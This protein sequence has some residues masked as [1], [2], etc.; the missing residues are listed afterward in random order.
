MCGRY[1]F[2]AE[3]CEEIR[4]IAQAIQKKYGKGAWTPGDVRPAN[5]AP[6][7][8]SEGGKLGP[9][10]M[11]WGYQA[12]GTLVINARAETAAAKPM[13]RESVRSRHCLIPSTGFYEWMPISES[14][15]L[16]SRAR[17]SYIWRGCMTDG[18]MRTATVS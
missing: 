8:L 16:P 7:I 6:V 13:F 12:P 2:T 11:K 10:L 18:T 4:R 1:Q 9:R 3:Q 14:I 5:V 17:T 15:S